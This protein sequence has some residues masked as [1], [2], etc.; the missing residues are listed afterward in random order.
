MGARPDHCHAGT[1]FH[2]FIP[3]V[4]LTTAAL[5]ILFAD[6]S[7]SSSTLFPS[8]QRGYFAGPGG[9]GLDRSRQSDRRLRACCPRCIE[10]LVRCRRPF[11]SRPTCS[12]P[13]PSCLP[14]GGLPKWSSTSVTRPCATSGARRA[15][16]VSFRR[17]DRQA[18]RR[19]RRCRRMEQGARAVDGEG[20]RGLDQ[21]W[22]GLRVEHMP[23]QPLATV[24]GKGNAGK[25]ADLLSRERD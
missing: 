23:P 5:Y 12:T 9:G 3:V 13:R 11:E 22:H 2:L 25:A 20:C 17:R 8:R 1:G 16:L 14:K 7:V 19:R 6:A 21:G 4:L 15:F 10:V 24:V 18:S